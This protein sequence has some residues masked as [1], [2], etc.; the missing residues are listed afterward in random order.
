MDIFGIQKELTKI[1]EAIHYNK[2]F[3][4]SNHAQTFITRIGFNVF[5]INLKD[6]IVKTH[7]PKVITKTKPKLT[8]VK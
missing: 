7:I 3:I 2:P 4:I 1:G 8:I 6:T 5:T